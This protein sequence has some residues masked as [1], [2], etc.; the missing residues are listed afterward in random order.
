MTGHTGD[1]MTVA[2]IYVNIGENLYQVEED[3]NGNLFSEDGDGVVTV[4]I[5]LT[6]DELVVSSY[7]L[8]AEHSPEKVHCDTPTKSWSKKNVFLVLGW[9]LE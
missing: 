7:R 9:N 1:T 3:D 5:N 2:A 4:I 8:L 6:D